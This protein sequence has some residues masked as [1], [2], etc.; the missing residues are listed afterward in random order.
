[1]RLVKQDDL[2]TTPAG[3]GKEGALLWERMSN[4]PKVTEVMLDQIERACRLRDQAAYC[5]LIIKKEGMVLQMGN[6]PPREHPLVKTE[7]ACEAQV[8]RILKQLGLLDRKP[9]RPGAPSHYPAWAGPDGCG[10]R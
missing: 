2:G 5:R 4:D 10:D 3:L 9:R 8:G 7:M 6:Y 1:M